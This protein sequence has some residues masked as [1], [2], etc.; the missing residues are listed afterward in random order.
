MGVKP[1]MARGSGMSSP[2][3]FELQQRKADG[4]KRMIHPNELRPAATE[5]VFHIGG[6]GVGA[7]GKI[8]E[9]AHYLAGECAED[10]RKRDRPAGRAENARG[11]RDIGRIAGQIV[12]K[13][14]GEGGYGGETHRQ[15]R[16][17]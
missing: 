8:R 2:R 13:R 6:R 1:G 15:E 16:A 17:G 9:E 10:G 4:G 7:V 12:E 14:R 3:P 5:S 11:E